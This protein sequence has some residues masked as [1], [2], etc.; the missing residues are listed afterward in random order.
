MLITRKPITG[1]YFDTN[2]TRFR[3]A[4]LPIAA[5]L[6]FLNILIS[7]LKNYRVEI[8]NLSLLLQN[9]LLGPILIPNPVGL[10]WQVLL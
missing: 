9:P 1:T 7:H 4:G 8:W 10:V 3:M 2:L 5:M 6:D